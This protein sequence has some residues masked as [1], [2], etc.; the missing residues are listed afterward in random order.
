MDSCRVNWKG[1][2]TVKDVQVRTAELSDL[3]AI[4]ELNYALFQ[5]DAGQRDPYTNL[6]WTHE[7]GNEHFAHHITAESSLCLVAELDS[8]IV[9]YLAGYLRQASSM[10]PIRTAELGSVFV[11]GDVR[12]QGVGQE[13][14]EPF[15]QWSGEQKAQRV[16]VTAYASNDGAIRFYRRLGFTPKEVALERSV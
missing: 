10:R 11:L 15:M 16:S 7:E 4:V 1:D 13:L 2:N 8:R 6:D 9:G 3:D 14:A 12:S 5:Q